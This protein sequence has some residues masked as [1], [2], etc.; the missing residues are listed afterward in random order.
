MRTSLS[1]FLTQTVEGFPVTGAGL[2]LAEEMERL[3]QPGSP[4][5]PVDLAEVHAVDVRHL[6]PGQDGP[7]A[8]QVVQL[9]HVD[10]DSV[11]VAGVVEV[12]PDDWEDSTADGLQ[13]DLVILTGGQVQSEHGVTVGVLDHEDVRHHQHQELLILRHLC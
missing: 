7:A 10:P 4:P 11:G 3:L 1:N 9:P 12:A 13:T 6:L 5:L 8:H 2:A